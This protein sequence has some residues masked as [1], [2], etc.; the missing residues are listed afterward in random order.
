MLF[1]KK[2]HRLGISRFRYGSGNTCHRPVYMA[3]H[4][5]RWNIRKPGGGGGLS[6]E[7]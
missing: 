3:I 5:I 4:R 6:E 7:E 1:G 2:C